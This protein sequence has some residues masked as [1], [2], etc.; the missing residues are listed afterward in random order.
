[1]A[2]VSMRKIDTLVD[3]LVQK[4]DYYATCEIDEMTE[5]LEA[6]SFVGYVETFLEV[7][8]KCFEVTD[9]NKTPDDMLSDIIAI[10]KNT[11][12]TSKEAYLLASS[13]EK[14]TF[15]ERRT[16][17]AAITVL[18]AMNEQ[19]GHLLPFEESRDLLNTVCNPY[20]LYE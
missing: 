10:G 9:S 17:W 1:M 11:L 2:E 7:L 14:D 6:R 5:P 16:C 19:V 8:N 4:R 3:M 15:Y 18:T 13:E 12:Q 20:F